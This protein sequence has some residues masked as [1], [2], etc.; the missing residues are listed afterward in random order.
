MG[1][2]GSRVGPG[3]AAAQTDCAPGPKATTG[4]AKGPKGRPP[5]RVPRHPRQGGP[6]SNDRGS[7]RLAPQ[8][9]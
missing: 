2:A 8:T 3:V 6:P 4:S 9:P 5:P 1:G 7:P